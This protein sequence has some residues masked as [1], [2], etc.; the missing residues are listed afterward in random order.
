[1]SAK[2]I[3]RSD[4]FATLAELTEFAFSWIAPTLL[5][6]SLTAATPTPPSATSSAMHATTMLGDRC[7]Q[8]LRMCS[9]L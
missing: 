6:G 4:L 2:S 9:P 3:A 7:L 5:A 1:L 8:S